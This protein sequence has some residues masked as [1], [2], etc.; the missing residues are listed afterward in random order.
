[1]EGR[2]L[3]GPAEGDGWLPAETAW[4]GWGGTP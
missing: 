2:K 3:P 1:M 4:R